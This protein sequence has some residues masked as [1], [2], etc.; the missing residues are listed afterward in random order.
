MKSF[1]LITAGIVG[2]T[3]NFKIN[4]RS[5]DFKNSITRIVLMYAALFLATKISLFYMNHELFSVYGMPSHPG[6]RARLF[7]TCD[8][9]LHVQRLL[10]AWLHVCQT[11]RAISC[12]L[13]TV[14]IGACLHSVF[15]ECRRQLYQEP[16]YNRLP[17]I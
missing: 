12:S 10:W 11:I 3:Y 17:Q 7:Q 16:V 2:L 13:L 1:R 8:H 4:D 5:L 6:W 9:V 14:G 15:H